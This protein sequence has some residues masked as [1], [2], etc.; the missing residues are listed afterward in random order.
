VSLSLSLLLLRMLILLLLLLL[1]ACTPV[2]TDSLR[3]ATATKLSQ[4]SFGQTPLFSSTSLAFTGANQAGVTSSDGT[5]EVKEVIVVMTVA[6][7]AAVVV[8]VCCCGGDLPIR[9]VVLFGSYSCSPA[10][11]LSYYPGA[12]ATVTATIPT[13]P[14]SAGLCCFRLPFSRMHAVV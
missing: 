7:C 10:T 12:A 3:G 6:V 13:A 4:V 5:A 2:Q 9:V 1:F 8:T 14:I 11:L